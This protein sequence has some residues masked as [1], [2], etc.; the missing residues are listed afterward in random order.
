MISQIAEAISAFFYSMDVI[1]EEENGRNASTRESNM[2]Y[3]TMVLC[4]Q[5]LIDLMERFIGRVND[6]L[7][8]SA[9]YR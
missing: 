9:Y 4:T 5:I 3:W 7:L 1:D 6:Y 2:H 8:Y